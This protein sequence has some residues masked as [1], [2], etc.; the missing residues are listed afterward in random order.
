MPDADII[1]LHEDDVL[2]L[3]QISFLSGY[4]RLSDDEPKY[5]FVSIIYEEKLLGNITDVYEC[6]FPYKVYEI[7]PFKRKRF[8]IDFNN[9]III[10]EPYCPYFLKKELLPIINDRIKPY[11]NYLCSLQKENQAELENLKD[12]YIVKLENEN[13]ILK[14]QLENSNMP[15]E[16]TTV[17]ATLWAS[18]CSAACDL[19][20]KIMSDDERGITNPMFLERMKAISPNK[21]THTDVDKLAWKALPDKYKNGPGRPKK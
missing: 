5:P 16:I 7:T 13:N 9:P 8:T 3:D 20:V 2:S 12:T 1:Y 19:L 11:V 10:L 21:R 14:K 4:Y 15:Q 18:S 6:V 17:D